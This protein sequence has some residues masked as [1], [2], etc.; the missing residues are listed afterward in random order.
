MHSLLRSGLASAMVLGLT[1]I[2]A[3]QAP[4]YEGKTVTAI[5]G[6][7]PGGG[8]DF[9]G[10][11][12]A[13]N[14][15]EHIAG[16]PNIVVENMPGAGSVLASN[17]Y[18][19]RAERDGTE[20]LVGTGQLLMRIVLGLE[21]STASLADLEPIVALPMG[22]ITFGSTEAG[23]EGPSD[24][25]DP[26]QPLVLG[27]P[28]VISTIDAVLGLELL[29]ADYQAIIGY[30]GK[31][32]AYLAFERGELNLDAQTTP[33]YLQ[34][35]AIAVD[36]GRAVP[37]FAQGLLDNQGELVRDPAAPDIPTVQEVYRELHGE[38]PSG[39]V[40]E[41]FKAA[42]TAIGNGGKILMIHSDAPEEAK[43]A[44]AE[45]VEGLLAD[46][47]FLAEA[48][49]ATEGY[50]FVAGSE[51][52]AAVQAVANMSEE[53]TQWLRDFLTENFEMQFE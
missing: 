47:E 18:V 4:Y 32:E 26:P 24:L 10:R 48:A 53:D 27:V 49:E 41:A 52:N 33:V 29:G 7:S 11:L 31:S 38:D 50:E 16:N 9:F 20:I 25:L 21:G 8:T 51:L 46:E 43:E 15:G 2:A 44:L 42:V 35:P 34:Q 23:I 40:W 45:A 19:D 22:R 17:Y 3:A 13:E 5:V 14:I 6:F 36:E 37:L 1:S 28:E 39:P 30:E 12:V